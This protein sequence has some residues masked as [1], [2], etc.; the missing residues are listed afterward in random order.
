MSAYEVG[1]ILDIF[2]LRAL[3]HDG[4]LANLFLAEDRLTGKEVVL[5]IPCCDILN[6]PVLLYHFQNED[7]I[8]RKLDHPGIVRFIHRQ[9]S[10]QYIIMEYVAG[11]DLRSFL[12][13]NK[14]FTLDDTLDLM[15]QLCGIVRYLHSQG[16]CHLDLKPENIICSANSRIKLIDFGLASCADFPDYLAHDLDSPLGTPWYIAPE[17]LLGERSDPRCDVYSMGMI[18]YE[19]LTGRLPW[20]K[21]GKLRIA[22]KRLHY[23]PA[24]PRFFTSTIPPQLQS[25]VL[26]AIARQPG[27]R[28]ATVSALH[29]DLEHW[30][31]LPVTTFGQEKTLPPFWKRCWPKRF[32]HYAGNRFVKGKQSLRPLIIGAIIDTPACNAMLAEIKKQALLRS[33]QITF[34]HVIEEEGDSHFRRYGITVEGEKLMRRIE[35]AVQLLRR[36]SIDPGLRLIR[37]EV[38]EVLQNLCEEQGVELLVLGSSRK[39]NMVFDSGSV[40][41]T[42]VNKC[43]VPVIVAKK[44]EAFPLTDLAAVAPASLTADQLIC[45][46]IFLVDLWYDQLHSSIDL[47]YRQLLITE[48][49][50]QSIVRDEEKSLLLQYINLFSL[51]TA[52]RKTVTPL[53][54]MYEQFVLLGNKIGTIPQGDAAGLQTIYLER[55]LPLTCKLKTRL[56]EI[57]KDLHERCSP[58]IAQLPFLADPLCPVHAPQMPCYGP[59]LRTFDLGQDLS[60]L[61]RKQK[62]ENENT[63]SQ[64]ISQ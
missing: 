9:R 4:P 61:L 11:S 63:C 57:S 41:G 48:P 30:Q 21:T 40:C 13:L 31:Q 5:K 19:L 38:V 16:V 17:Q 1:D 36:C 56:A 37:G 32:T 47:M 42:L 27:D 46:D 33:A 14:H 24:P 59:L 28:Y 7:R 25:I 18:M 6:K 39:K 23:N 53:Q 43:A 35:E 8:S 22:R 2:I 58:G 10:R 62:A 26:Q 34:V 29:N 54:P 3:L 52:W 20:E 15:K 64:E 12:H 55:L 50:T 60:S 44:D 51:N 45:F 49:A